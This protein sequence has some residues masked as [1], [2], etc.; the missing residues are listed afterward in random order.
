MHTDL[1]A[2]LHSNHC[3]ELIQ[4]LHKCHD[5]NPF[6]K[7]FG[8]C[9]QEDAEM[10]RCLKQE[11]IARRAQNRIKSEEMKKRWKMNAEAS[12]KREKGE[13]EKQT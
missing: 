11:R 13:A 12:A 2:H 7:F 9:N 5:E 10:L 3:N 1:S 6:K 8:Y 4:L